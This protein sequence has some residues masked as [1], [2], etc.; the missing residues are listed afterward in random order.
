LKITAPTGGRVLR[1]FQE[2]AGVVAPGTQL[3]EVGDPQD[4]ELKIDVL[5]QDAVRIQPGARVYVEGWG[6]KE[7]LTAAVRLVEPTAFLKVSA[8]GVE[9][10]RVNVIADFPRPC[11]HCAGMGDGYRIEAR[12]VVDR[13]Q[14]VIVIPSGALVRDGESWLVFRVDDDIARRQQVDV[15]I[16]N[17]LQTEIRSGLTEGDRIILYPSD[18]IADGTTLRSR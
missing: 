15:G 6:G 3:L 18:K 4:L 14:G 10:K 16:S 2:D 1:V 7:S 11:V 8:L 13:A 9:E 12:I 17:G 5:S